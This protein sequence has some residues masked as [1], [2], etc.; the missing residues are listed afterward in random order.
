MNIGIVTTWFERGAA[1][2]SRQFMDVLQKTDNVFIYARAGESYAIGNPKWDLDNV[3]WGKRDIGKLAIL[4]TYIEKKDFVKWLKKYNIDVVIFNEQNWLTPV[5]WCKDE[6]IKA[7]AYIDYYN[8]LMIPLFNVYDAVICNTKRHAFAFRHHPNVL[9]LKW[10]TNLNLYKFFNEEHDKLTFFNSAGMDPRR[11]G[12]DYTIRA[13]YNLKNRQKAKLLIHSQV[14]VCQICNELSDIVKELKEEGSLEII[15]ETISAPGL[16]H[17]ADVYVYPSRLDGIGLTL[18]EAIASGMACITVDNGPM[19]EFVEDNFGKLCKVD[20]FYCRADG[21][22]WPMCEINVTSL[23]SIMQA[24][25][26]GEYDVELM[27]KNARIY[28]EKELDFDKNIQKL[29]GILA[30]LEYSKVSQNLRNALY[31]Y[32]HRGLKR[33]VNILSPF[34]DIAYRLK[35]KK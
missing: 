14:S 33:F 34:Y 32:D 30:S 28:A 18:M 17:K 19:N 31:L 29:S 11:K 27:K 24:Y 3:H 10:G 23:T 26:N 25:V 16:Y 22:Y 2:V 6:G 1:Y 5:L 8:E 20:Y 21:Y 9:Y 35:G 15:E 13:F 7:V 12:T 4:S